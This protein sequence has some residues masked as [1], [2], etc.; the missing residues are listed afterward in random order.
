MAVTPPS[1]TFSTVEE[2]IGEFSESVSYYDSTTSLAA[3]V[4]SVT[5][6][7]SDPGITISISGNTVTV[8]GR[9][10][11]IFTDK[12]WTYIPRGQTP[13]EIVEGVYYSEIPIEIEALTSYFPDKSVSRL[14]TYSVSTTAGSATIEQTVTNNWDTGK[15]Q[16]Y[17]V[18]ARGV[19]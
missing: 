15:A 11:Q 10:T 13:E 5:A 19:I 12:T 6:S 2:V 1:T 3:G 9:Y 18:L 14:V 8:S 16:M 4:N 7:Q 17:E